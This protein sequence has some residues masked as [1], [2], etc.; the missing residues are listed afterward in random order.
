M[1]LIVLLFFP[2]IDSSFVPPL[3]AAPGSISDLSDFRSPLPL[4]N[5]SFSGYSIR[6]SKTHLETL[7]PFCKIST[8]CWIN[9]TFIH[10]ASFLE[11]FS[12]NSPYFP[13][14]NSKT[15]VTC[16]G[17]QKKLR[18][19]SKPEGTKF[20]CP[21]CSE[22]ITI[23]DSDT[24]KD[25]T[26]EFELGGPPSNETESNPGPSS[27][28]NP[29]N[30]TE[31]SSASASSSPPSSSSASSPSQ[32]GS[33]NQ[34]RQ[35]LTDLPDESS[36]SSTDSTGTTTDTQQTSHE[37]EEEESAGMV[38]L[39]TFRELFLESI[40]VTSQLVKV[41]FWISTV[42]MV[43]A[44]VAS[45]GRSPAPFALV[46]LTILG[47]FIVRVLAELIIISLRS[48]GMLDEDPR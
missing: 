19:K 6:W 15:V 5:H 20:K 39:L 21:N 23:P 1:F 30:S 4:K 41:S 35:E 9:I 18:L 24:A 22:V 37:Y 45:I 42:I 7:P 48:A 3:I 44:C 36:S 2:L 10:K 40:S 17:C 46:L 16:S 43:L 26:D 47:I 33:S 29:A 27:P 13:M 11:H 14:S 38:S 8:S 34:K 28:S 32:S 12:S 31:T 25:T